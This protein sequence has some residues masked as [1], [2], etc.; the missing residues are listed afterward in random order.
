MKHLLLPMCQNLCHYC[1]RLNVKNK[2]SVALTIT[3]QLSPLNPFELNVLTLF[4][5][6]LFD[7]KRLVIV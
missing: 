5:F 1:R 4:K 2:S 6:Q 7:T 3:L